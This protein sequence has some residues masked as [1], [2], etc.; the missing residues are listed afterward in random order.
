MLL[1]QIQELTALLATSICCYERRLDLSIYV[2]VQYLYS[3][4]GE[5]AV[6]IQLE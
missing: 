5:R 2:L 4:E 3:V 6:G 1:R